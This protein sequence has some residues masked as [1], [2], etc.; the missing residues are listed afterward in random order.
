VSAIASASRPTRIASVKRPV[1]MR[2]RL[3]CAV[4]RATSRSPLDQRLGSVEVTLR[5][6]PLPSPPH[7]VSDVELRDRRGLHVALLKEEV[8]RSP[9]PRRASRAGLSRSAVSRPA[10]RASSSAAR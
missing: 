10:A 4:A 1:T 2:Y 9:A 5:L 8:A 6:L 7:L 3:R